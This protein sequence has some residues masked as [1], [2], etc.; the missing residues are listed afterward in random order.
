M[1]MKE[2]ILLL[3]V[4]IT[5]ISC[6]KKGTILDFNLI[7]GIPN[8]VDSA[9]VILGEH[10][11]HFALDKTG[12]GRLVMDIEEDAFAVL[13]YGKLMTDVY[14]K[15]GNELKITWNPKDWKGSEI[16]V[17]SE[18]NGINQYIRYNIENAFKKAVACPFSLNDEEYVSKVD[19]TIKSLYDEIENTDFQE[20]VKNALKVSAKYNVLTW[21]FKYPRF[22]NYGKRMSQEDYF[23]FEH[24]LKYIFGQFEAL[25]EYLGI[26]SYRDY[27]KYWFYEYMQIYA[28]DDP[29]IV[30]KEKAC[31]Y[32]LDHVKDPVLKEYAIA[33]TIIPYIKSEGIEKSDKLLNY[34]KQ[35]VNNPLYVRSFERNYSYWAKVRPGS[36]SDDFCYK[37]IDGKQVKLSD[38]K[39]KY[40][41][42]DIWATWCKPCCYE[43]PFIQEIEHRLKDKNIVFVSISEDKDINAWKAMVKKENMGG[44]Q[45]N[46]GGNKDFMNYFYITAIPRFII[47]DPEQ[48][49][50]TARAPKP[51][52]GDL[53]KMLNRLLN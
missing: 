6:G 51:S 47:I 42:I 31:Q 3:G 12:H 50:V 19:S 41:C 44:V 23:S 7:E 18:D 24:F 33:N 40:V 43:I 29:Y 46:Y 15:E 21:I 28:F 37:D 49:I 26:T 16:E 9:S 27:V 52:S 30:R 38:F 13:V 4:I 45:L 5:C 20:D 11:Y 8:K 2:I 34:F 35:N 14:L 36:E 48:K 1:I 22:H 53:E 17:K 10:E 25:P 39:G 32:I